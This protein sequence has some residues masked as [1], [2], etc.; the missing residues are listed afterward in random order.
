MEKLYFKK[1][2]NIIRKREDKA[3]K[4][5]KKWKEKLYVLE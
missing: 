3:K 5:Y 2:N 1:R 4:L